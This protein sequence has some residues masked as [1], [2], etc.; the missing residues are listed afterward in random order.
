MGSP[1]YTAIDST[2][3]S[4]SM[5]TDN[6]TNTK[7]Q[8]D[9]TLRCDPAGGTARPSSILVEIQSGNP[10]RRSIKA[11]PSR[12]SSV[13]E[14]APFV[15]WGI[16]WLVPAKMLA[17]LVAG[18]ALAIGHHCYYHSLAGTEVL[19]SANQASTWDTNRQEWKIRFG[20]AFAFL[21]KTCLASSIAIAYTQ[22]IWASC[23]KKA[24][25]ISGLDALFS[26]T[27]DV[28]AFA[29]L[30]LTVRAKIDAVLAAFVWSV[31]CVLCELL[32]RKLQY[33]S[34]IFY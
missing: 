33:L 17:L 3:Y 22:H 1:K 13:H 29:S 10:T 5:L 19:S 34:S 25:S 21:A 14:T 24:F 6:R 18:I 2:E 23:R 7:P 12:I 27:S 16:H 15:K 8:D 11:L 20:T 31:K 9:A 26:A 28:F 4:A 30:D 32:L